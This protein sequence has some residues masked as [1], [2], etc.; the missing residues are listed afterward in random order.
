M[1]YE[2]TMIRL[3]LQDDEILHVANLR[4]DYFLDTRC[5][6]VFKAIEKSFSEWG[7][8]SKDTIN[9][10]MSDDKL[11][12]SVLR[13]ADEEFGFRWSALKDRMLDAW[14]RKAIQDVF[15]EA[16]ESM[17]SAIDANDV[18]TQVIKDVQSV[19]SENDGDDIT[20]KQLLRNVIE[21]IH[22]RYSDTREIPGLSSGL[23]S[24]D[25]ALGGFQPRRYYLIGARPSRAKSALLGQIADN[26][27]RDGVPVGFISAESS[28]EELITRNV[29]RYNGI[30]LFR[31]QS[32]ALTKSHLA[33]LDQETKNYI[34]L[35][36]F[37][38]AKRKPT[39]GHIESRARLWKAKHDIKALFV[40]YVQIADAPGAWD[41]RDSV[42]KVSRSL[43]DLSVSLGI[44]VIAA[45]QLKRDVDNREPTLGDFQHSS[46]LEQ[47]ADVAI[48]LHWEVEYGDEVPIVVSIEKNRDGGKKR[49]RFNFTGPLVRFKESIDDSI[50]PGAGVD[51]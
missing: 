24:L 47:D 20:Y 3:I 41:K 50:V 8:V 40:D 5:R 49:V 35:P 30:E 34:N 23:R 28:A 10:S 44:P 13:E 21:Q 19:M 32:G 16:K 31:L 27:A 9:A 15:A 37:I 14:K 6:S 29:A 45:A 26:I 18:A 4:R 42:E 46:A 48:L 25:A 33:A 22:E 39:I 7:Y 43:K 2:A 51:R 1:N 38:D 17:Q 36:L 12:D 11:L